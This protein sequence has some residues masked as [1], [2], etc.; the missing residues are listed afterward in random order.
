[1]LR[2]SPPPTVPLSSTSSVHRTG[3]VQNPGNASRVRD[4]TRGTRSGIRVDRRRA[5]GVDA[6]Q[7]QG[8]VAVCGGLPHGRVAGCNGAFH[9]RTGLR[10]RPR[11]LPGPNGFRAR[12][13]RAPHVPY[14]MV[15]PHSTRHCTTHLGTRNHDGPGA[16]R[17]LSQQQR[18]R[19]HQG[20][21]MERLGRPIGQLPCPLHVP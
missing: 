9:L 14:P 11:T 21:Q 5:G 3:R 15:T 4:A 17:C 16:S 7:V 18:L 10:H 6:V 2:R 12:P 1:M 20:K 8:E 13:P 19:R